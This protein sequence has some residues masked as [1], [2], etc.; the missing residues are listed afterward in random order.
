M[1]P[2]LQGIL[3]DPVGLH[4]PYEQEPFERTPRTPQKDQEISIGAVSWP[5]GAAEQVWLEWSLDGEAGVLTQVVHAEKSNSDEERDHWKLVLPAFKNGQQ[6]TYQVYAGQRE[7]QVSCGPFS[8]TIPVW[9]HWRNVTAWRSYEKGIQLDI[10]ASNPALHP[11]L[12]IEFEDSGQLRLCITSQSVLAAE[13]LAISGSDSPFYRIIEDSPQSL[14]VESSGLRLVINRQP[15]S[16]S[17]YD[18]H[19]NPLLR[20][21]GSPAFLTDGSGQVLEL[22]EEFFSPPAEGFYGFGER[23]NGFNQRG[24]RL[25]V[26]VYDQYKNQGLRTY[27]PMPFFISSNGYGLYLHTNRYVKY[28]L[29]AG[30][31]DTWSYQAELGADGSLS[32]TLFTGKPAEVI[33][34]FTSLT[35]KPKQPPAWVFGP[36]MSSN[37]WNRQ[38]IIMEQVQQTRQLDIPAT[39]LVIEAWSDENTFYIWND[40]QYT[41]CQS[42]EAFSYTDFNFPEDGRW[43][44]PKA[45]VDELHRSGIK[46]VLWQIPVFR[47]LDAPHLQHEADI[48]YAIEHGYC[49]RETD[50]SP[51]RVRS[52]WFKNS[53]LLDATNPEAVDWW[54]KKRA[55]LLDDLGVDGFK[56]DGGE[57]IWG[58]DLL[59][60]NGMR[61]DE[62]WNL[63]P[64]LYVGAY[65]EFVDRKRNGQGA[66][67]SR[68]GFT[69]AQAYPCHWAGDENSTW[70]AFR[71]SIRCGLNIGLS[72]VPFW[73][74][75]IAGFSGEIPSAELYLRSTAMAAFC[76]IM[77]Y[78]SELS[79][80][81]GTLR[82]R[83]PWNIAERTSA[84]EVVAIYRKYA[85]LRMKLLRYI[86]AEAAYCAETGEP[87]MRSLLLDWPEIPDVWDIADQY[88]FGRSLLVAPVIEP[89]AQERTLYLPPGEWQ[90]LWDGTLLEGGR[91]IKR[92]APISLIPVY[93]RKDR[94]SSELEQLIEDLYESKNA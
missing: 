72:G 19:G 88:C 11:Q 3:H 79:P 87:M 81:L 9:S 73:G 92:P 7:R 76:P 33:Q 78:H 59:F 91:W 68:A 69:G 46:L 65:H 23:F 29:A 74:W 28:D 24:N 40:A 63:Y 39:V 5:V 89:G 12:R 62:V 83:T 20:G 94:P 14:V 51:Y 6:V 45:M 37:E 67:F 52:N 8:F 35:G 70:E 55:Y 66:T 64:N 85:H 42:A 93:L 49:V 30:T 36:W 34:S 2:I 31:K 4:H 18:Q 16:L 44:D 75:D 61:G 32:Y 58:R 15:Y 47:A 71:V 17:V 22:Q 90:D 26:R 41:P 54:L 53:H 60:S 77:Q 48:A 80:E 56:T 13:T 21:S 84:P 86:Q 25:D 27:I 50:G 1:E 10:S 57:H 43:P 82:D 38:S